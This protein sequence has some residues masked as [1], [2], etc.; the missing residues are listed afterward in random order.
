MQN[1]RNKLKIKTLIE[2]KNTFRFSMEKYDDVIKIS[3]LINELF[4]LSLEPTMQMKKVNYI[5]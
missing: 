2:Y 1:P 5:V 3:V 4:Y